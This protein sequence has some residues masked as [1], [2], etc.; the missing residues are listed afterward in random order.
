MLDLYSASTLECG[1]I[2]VTS[3][4][5]WIPKAYWVLHAK[6]ILKGTQ[7]RCCVQGPITPCRSSESILEEHTND[8]HHRKATIGNLCAQLFGLLL[9]I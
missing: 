9:S 1:H 3:Q 5:Q 6:L 7:G 2:A 4:A 8:C